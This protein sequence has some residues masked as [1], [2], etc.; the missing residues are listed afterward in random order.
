MRIRPERVAEAMKREVADIIANRLRDPRLSTMISVTDVEV[1]RDLSLARVFVS[2]LAGEPERALVM[3]A[4]ARSAGFVRHELST[5]IELREMPELRF[6]LDTSIE[7]GARVEEL[8]R[9][10][11]DGEPAPDDEAQ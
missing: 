6:A 4:L 10:I 1:T 9:R 11:H 3:A 8:L 7:Q 5:R 2:V